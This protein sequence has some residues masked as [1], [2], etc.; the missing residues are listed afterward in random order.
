MIDPLK[1]FALGDDG[2][3]YLIQN[4]RRRLTFR[5]EQVI[6]GSKAPENSDPDPEKFV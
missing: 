6:D 2:L 1:P 3:F 4:I 5:E